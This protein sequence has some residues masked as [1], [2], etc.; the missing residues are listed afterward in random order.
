MIV[1]LV[2]FGAYYMFAPRD[3]MARK[4][5]QADSSGQLRQVERP[6]HLLSLQPTP[7][8]LEPR[9]LLD[10]REHLGL[11]Q[12]QIEKLGKISEKWSDEK[13]SLETQLS[14]ETA[15][16]RDSKQIRH[17]VRDIQSQLRNYSALSSE[18]ADRREIAWLAATAILTDEQK[19]LLLKLE[20]TAVKP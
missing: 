11:A 4:Y 20:N 18:Y 2:G 19:Q 14:G 13:R 16:L 12:K 17:S 8:K 6:S 10:H 7:Q 15:F 3:E 9:F 5:F 1:G